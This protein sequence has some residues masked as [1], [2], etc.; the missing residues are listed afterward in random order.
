[1]RNPAHDDAAEVRMIHQNLL[2]RRHAIRPSIS[3]SCHIKY[4]KKAKQMKSLEE[5]DADEQNESE[6]L[7]DTRGSEPA[8]S[9]VERKR[10]Y[11]QESSDHRVDD[12]RLSS[13]YRRIWWEYENEEGN[14]NIR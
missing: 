12:F 9:E 14:F 6:G 11:R 10:C 13:I 1:M 4:S 3:R 5:N 7:N 2:Y 8:L